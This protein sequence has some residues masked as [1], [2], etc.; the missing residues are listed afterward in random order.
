MNHN[1]S[2]PLRTRPRL[3]GI[4][5]EMRFS[6][7]SSSVSACS[8]PIASGIPP[9]NLLIE[10]ERTAKAEQ[11]PISPSLGMR[12]LLCFMVPSWSIACPE[13][14]VRVQMH[15]MLPKGDKEGIGNSKMQLDPAR[16]PAHDLYTTTLSL[17]AH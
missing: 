17:E 11:Q 5:L 10:N 2:V 12:Q 7:S 15:L 6:S 14:V 9:A 16:E 13:G 1:V 8:A 3:A 4:M